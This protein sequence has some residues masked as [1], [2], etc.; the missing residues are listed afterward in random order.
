VCEYIESPWLSLGVI[1]W[2]R[3]GPPDFLVPSTHDPFVFKGLS[4]GDIEANTKGLGHRS[5]N[6]PQFP[7][8]FSGFSS[9]SPCSG[10]P[11]CPE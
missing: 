2:E 7:L 3:Q 9:E 6:L 5:N 1:A 11:L 4:T 10:N 8:N